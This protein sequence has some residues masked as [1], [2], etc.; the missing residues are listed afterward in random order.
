MKKI[1]NCYRALEQSD[2]IKK[3]DITMDYE[4]VYIDTKY[5]ALEIFRHNDEIRLNGHIILGDKC[6]DI[7]D[8]FDMFR[9]L[10]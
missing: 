1:K 10:K 8:S 7:L 3:H 2:L 4:S 9:R 5:G 6:D